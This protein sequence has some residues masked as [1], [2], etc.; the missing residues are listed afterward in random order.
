MIAAPRVVVFF[1]GSDLSSSGLYWEH[2]AQTTKRAAYI[3]ICSSLQRSLNLA[4]GKGS[5]MGTKHWN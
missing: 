3:D 4:T 1:L 5:N 2:V